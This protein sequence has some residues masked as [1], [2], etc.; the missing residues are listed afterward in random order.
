MDENNAAAARI[1][2]KT[3]ELTH[4]EQ[5]GAQIDP[6]LDEVLTRMRRLIAADLPFLPD[7][8]Q[9]RVDSLERLL[10]DPEVSQSERL[11]KLMEAL[12]VELEYGQTIE[13]TRQTIDI[14][15]EATLVNLF[16]LGRLALFYQHLDGGDCGFYNIA[17][18]TW[19]PLPR[20]YQG[21]ILAAMEMGAKQ[22][23]VDI[24]TLPIGRIEIE[25]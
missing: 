20:R 10:I 19:Q 21:A 15:G 3:T 13:V 24:L 8:R 7:E 22:R 4:M 9:R 6:F 2:E 16:R 23:P 12:M 1:A 11:R 5:I 17:E 14:A 25:K 18:G